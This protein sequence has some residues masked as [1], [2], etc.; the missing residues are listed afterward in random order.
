MVDKEDA[1][2]QGPGVMTDA[3]KKMYGQYE[4]GDTT[5]PTKL[6]KELSKDQEGKL[7]ASAAKW[8]SD[9]NEYIR[10][11][12]DSMDWS[13]Q[14]P[15][16]YQISSKEPFFG[17]LSRR[18]QKIRTGSIPTAGVVVQDGS[19][20]MYW[21]PIFFKHELEKMSVLFPTGVI[22]HELYHIVFEHITKRI[23]KP[24]VLWNV[25]T[26]CAINCLL[27]ENELPDFCLKP[28]HMYVPANPPPGWK[29]SI[30]AGIVHKFPKEQSAEWYM[31]HLLQND[32]VKQAMK[33]AQEDCASSGNG[34]GDSGEGNFEQSLKKKLFGDDGGQF[35][36]HAGWEKLSDTDR[37]MMRDTIRD[38][39]R[40]IAREINSNNSSWG[41]V[42]SSA[43]QHLKSLFSKEIDW[44][45]LISRFIGKSKSSVT[46]SSLK[47][48]S[49]RAPWDFP[50]RKRAYS[51]RPVV[52][53][54]Q[55]GSME[56]WWVELLFAEM[57]NIGALTEYE[58]I[59]FDTQVDEKN[60]QVIKRGQKPKTIRTC[61]G[62]TS[63][64]APIDYVNKHS[65]R[66]DCL[67]LL[68]DGGCSAPKKCV[69]PMAYILA[70][71]CKLYFDP[72]ETLVIM[73]TDTRAK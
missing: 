38:M 11:W 61:D 66:F 15:Y 3:K 58:I 56:N 30:I 54:D 50:G 6:P 53:L 25:A 40:G 32:K 22:K 68:T 2:T 8:L 10:L 46:T 4:T 27:E 36:D 17:S 18:I 14:V 70:P 34:S 73:M 69:V 35:D 47:R 44:R 41:S 13:I 19:L 20:Q 1:V 60:I 29:P 37:D 26:D 7:P 51:A 45:D 21:N 59:P 39:L 23:Q 5:P 65:S 49:R 12:N 57:S 24:H 63:F 55:S 67:F 72:G 16:L 33:E 43:Q 31:H 9:L 42:H 52:A 62:G 28:G 48:V 64:D 71:G